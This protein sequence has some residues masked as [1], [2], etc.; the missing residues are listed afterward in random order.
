METWLKWLIAAAC[1]VVIGF[2][3]NA[4]FGW[5]Q[6]FQQKRWLANYESECD[7]TLQKLADFVKT[8]SAYED[9]AK[10]MTSRVRSC[11]EILAGTSFP[12]YAENTMRKVGYSLNN[13]VALP[14]AD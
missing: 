14:S 4:I 11:A 5:Y 10:A 12:E 13:S 9:Q 3:A 2:G 8:D 7:A 1:V 6:D